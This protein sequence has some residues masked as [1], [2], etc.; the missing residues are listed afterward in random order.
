MR[1]LLLGKRGQVGSEINNL[2]KNH[3]YEIIAFNSS[4]L[5]VSDENALRKKIFEIKPSLIINAT[6]YTNVDGAEQNKNEAT[7]VNEIAVGNIAKVCGEID[8]ILF[9]ISTDYVFDGN[10][11]NDYS[12]DDPTNP[13][14]FYGESKLK[15]EEIIKKKLEKHI[16]L[17]TSWVYGRFGKNF[18]KTMI[19]N[20]DAKELSVVSDQ[21]GKPTSARSIAE[22]ALHI[23]KKVLLENK[24]IYG[25]FH[26]SN[27]TKLSWYEFSIKIFDVAH[28]IGVIKTK[29]KI[30]PVKTKDINQTAIRPIDSS[31]SS[32]KLSKIIKTKLYS[33]ENELTYVLNNI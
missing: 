8:C 13:L 18:V 15:G 30:K 29:P 11:I 25:V 9:H 12:E 4:E 2:F 26:F 20:S 33:I 19:S 6:A 14:N 17:R 7:A 27:S 24:K 16:I 31:L 3:N 22:V 21:F 23:S 10:K 28:A 32:E 1:V 5:D